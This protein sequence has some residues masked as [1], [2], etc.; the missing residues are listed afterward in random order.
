[1]ITVDF[2]DTVELIALRQDI[3]NRIL[4]MREEQVALL[5]DL[6]V[7]GTEYADVQLSVPDA[8]KSLEDWLIYVRVFDRCANKHGLPVKTYSTRVIFS[9]KTLGEKDGRLS[10]ADITAS[11]H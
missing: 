1:M 3:A 6:I 5:S 11:R 9:R 2:T 10:T 4:A 8:D 7:K